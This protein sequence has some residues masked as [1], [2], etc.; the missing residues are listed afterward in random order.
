MQVVREASDWALEV[1]NER[2]LV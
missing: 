1:K 2:A